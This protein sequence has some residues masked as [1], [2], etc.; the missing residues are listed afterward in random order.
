MKD[1]MTR[2]NRLDIGASAPAGCPHPGA[3]LTVSPSPFR[4]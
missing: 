1:Q 2:W 3:F 4:R